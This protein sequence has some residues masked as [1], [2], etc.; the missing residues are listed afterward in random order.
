MAIPA[1]AAVAAPPPVS[2][3]EVFQKRPQ[4]VALGAPQ[5][6]ALLMPHPL[7]FGDGL[8]SQLPVPG[9]R[10]PELQQIVFGHNLGQ[11]ALDNSAITDPVDLARG[12]ARDLSTIQAGISA[13]PAN[14]PLSATVLTDE[15]E[16]KIQALTAYL[17]G[18]TDM[19]AVTPLLASLVPISN[20]LIAIQAHFQGTLSDTQ[21]PAYPFGSLGLTRLAA[22]V[23][24][25]CALHSKEL[26]RFNPTQA[27]SLT[28]LV[29]AY[30]RQL[31][32]R[33]AIEPASTDPVQANV[34]KMRMG[35]LVDLQMVDE[36][37][38]NWFAASAEELADIK[39]WQ[40]IAQLNYW[41]LNVQ[42]GDMAAARTKALSRLNLL[43][44][45]NGFAQAEGRVDATQAR[46]IIH[47]LAL[48]Q[49]DDVVQTNLP[50]SIQDKARARIVTYF[51]AQPQS[52]ALR[53]QM[54]NAI[55][56]LIGQN[57]QLSTDEQKLF[58]DNAMF[59]LC[60]PG[61]QY[62]DY[63][64][65]GDASQPIRVSVSDSGELRVKILKE[66]SER[67]LP[68]LQE[69]RRL[70]KVM[71]RDLFPVKVGVWRASDTLGAADEMAQ[72][73][74]EEAIELCSSDFELSS[75]SDYS[76]SP[77]VY[78]I[79]KERAWQFLVQSG[80]ATLFLRRLWTGP[81]NESESEGAQTPQTRRA[82]IMARQELR[83][84]RSGE[85]IP[86]Q[87]MQQRQAASD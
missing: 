45:L 35:H 50:T 20:A 3:Q 4:P 30:A 86:V 68:F 19:K 5:N 16:Q 28:L 67:V 46:D 18:N 75:V 59:L 31:V 81:S 47:D 48:L 54:S 17:M 70:N 23:A 8:A 71:G 15:I 36:A 11:W 22:S 41:W 63:L 14:V 10:Q 74:L 25:L 87:I 78:E 64:V 85:D 66:E 62:A 38:D 73:D 69:L 52:H 83:S 1:S 9:M 58:R 55:R 76:E 82:S 34:L 72:M 61:K 53:A 43:R 32:N 21:A 51:N 29:G 60:S 79:E 65:G 49:D 40:D 26:D 7:A 44:R 56:H 77:P 37:A 13:Q 24:Y 80:P 84:A 33:G 6:R 39:Q 12:L 42:I 57:T 27:Q 2:L